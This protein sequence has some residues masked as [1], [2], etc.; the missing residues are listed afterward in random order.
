MR[1]FYYKQVFGA[2]VSPV[3]YW[4]EWAA[5]Q[6]PSS[7]HL[8]YMSRVFLW[9]N[10]QTGRLSRLFLAIFHRLLFFHSASLSVT[11]ESMKAN[12]ISGDRDCLPALAVDVSRFLTITST[13]MRQKIPF[14]HTQTISLVTQLNRDSGKPGGGVSAPERIDCVCLQ[15]E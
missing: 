10:C 12:D 6:I 13:S 8:A 9:S 11:R 7:G 14:D 2:C 15:S 4:G 5:Q 3:N 1:I